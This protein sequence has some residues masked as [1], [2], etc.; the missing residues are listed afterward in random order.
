[1]NYYRRYLGDY[2]RDTAHLSLTEHGVYTVLLDTLYATEKPLPAEPE[3]IYRICRAVTEDERA[4]VDAVVQQFF[5]VNGVGRMNARARREIEKGQAAIERMRQKGREG[6]K[7]RWGGD[8]E[9]HGVPHDDPNGVPNGVAIDPPSSNH[10]SS[11]K[12]RDRGRASRF[13]PPSVEEVREYIHERGSDVDAQKWHDHY[14][15]KGWRI[16]KSPM[17]DWRAAVRTWERGSTGGG[18]FDNLQ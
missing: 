14:S 16:G 13:T 15:A 17:K 10:Q 8:R 3:A 11:T 2:A 1:M 5:P 4:A 6:A 9:P 7:R 12:G 18:M